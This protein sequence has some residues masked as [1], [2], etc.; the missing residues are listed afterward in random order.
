M[1]NHDD[2]TEEQITETDNVPAVEEIASDVSEEAP[3]TGMPV[4]RQLAILGLVLVG[5]FTVSMIPKVLASLTGS[6]PR[7]ETA[8]EEGSTV[9][10]AAEDTIVP[11]EDIALRAEAAFVWDVNTQR[12]LYEKNP[13]EQLP[14]ASITKLMT[15]LVAHEL[16]AGETS[17][18]ID[19]AAIMQDGDSG[20]RGGEQFALQSL[21]DFTLMSSSNDGAFAMAAAAG[22]LLDE[23]AP[24]ENFVESMNIRADELGLTQTYFRNPTGLDI[25]ET[26]AGAFASARDMAF[27][28]EYILTE[29][30]EILEATTEHTD[31]FYN[32]NGDYHQ[33]ENTNYTVSRIPGIIG[34]KTG[35]TTLAGGNLAV[36]FDASLNRPVIVV[37][38]GSSYN[39]R[40]DDVLKLTKAVQGA[41]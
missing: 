6:V 10:P 35:Y 33:A 8:I 4:V 23:H 3:D 9:V 29:K 28:M 34:S 27:L 22:A 25:S 20:L 39:G 19:Y 2:T 1:T 5:L 40:F 13:D 15:A 17:V 41:E 38:L 18:S 26:E 24:T 30:P 11:I 21:S 7:Q 14:I 36:A 37:V 31:V 32:E 12:V 16:I